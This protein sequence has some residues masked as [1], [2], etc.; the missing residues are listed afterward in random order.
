MLRRILSGFTSR[1][2]F[3]GPEGSR[4]YAIGDI[5]GRADLLDVLLAR[6]EADNARRGPAKTYLIFLGDMVDRGP[7]SRG[8]IERLLNRPPTFARNIFLKGNHEEFFLGVL[9]GDDSIVQHWLAYGGTEC[10][11]SYGL[12]SGWMLNASPTGI[13]ERLIAQ[14]PAE[15]VRFV[16][17][18]AD[19]FRFGDYLFVHAG[20]R[21][22]V[23][24]DKQASKD[25]RWIREGFLDDRRDHGVIV[26][27][28][29]T[30]VD[31]PEEHPNRIAVDTGAYRS[32]VLTAIGLEGTDRWFIEA[33]AEEAA[34]A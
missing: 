4:A 22:G 15:H 13:M 1:R 31:R 30:I 33:R 2:A 5:H 34:A 18:L 16:H 9:Q 27:H 19:S 25:L 23:D 17:A 8:V 28:G 6:I 12:S 7:D 26:V 11:E 20:I 29:H 32:G 3:C 10:C 21:P 24:L 14:V